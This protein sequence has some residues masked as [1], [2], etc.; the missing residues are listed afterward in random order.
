MFTKPVMVAWAPEAEGGIMQKNQMIV[1][2]RLKNKDS[3]TN[4]RG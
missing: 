1:S 4:R 3:K 2:L